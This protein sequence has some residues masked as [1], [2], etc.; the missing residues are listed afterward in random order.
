[1]IQLADHLEERTHGRFIGGVDDHITHALGGLPR[2][3]RSSTSRDDI[4]A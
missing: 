4:G 3:E 1:M 2:G